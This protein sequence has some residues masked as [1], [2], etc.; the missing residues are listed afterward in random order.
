MVFLHGQFHIIRECDRCRDFSSRSPLVCHIVCGTLLVT[1]KD[2]NCSTI[3]P[4]H[5][6]TIHVT[7]LPICWESLRPRD[8]MKECATIQ[9]ILYF[10]FGTVASEGNLAQIASANVGFCRF[11]SINEES[12]RDG[13]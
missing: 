8:P 1:I 5:I 10:T 3:L 4:C 11:S 12:N 2:D 9:D 7:E 6:L 13:G